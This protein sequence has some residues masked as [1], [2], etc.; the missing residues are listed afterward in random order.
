M[1][2]TYCGSQGT[3]MKA[4]E[5]LSVLMAQGEDGTFSHP[6]L[7]GT[8]RRHSQGRSPHTEA[9]GHTLC[10]LRG[11]HS[12]HPKPKS[13]PFS[14]LIAKIRKRRYETRCLRRSSLPIHT[15]LSN[16]ILFCSTCAFKNSSKNAAF[17]PCRG[18]DTIQYRSLFPLFCG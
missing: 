12:F 6:S 17:R 10:T 16:L 9:M 15:F 18:G 3:G 1:G 14:T 5:G 11:K 4:R 7:L 2:Q 13:K 8:H